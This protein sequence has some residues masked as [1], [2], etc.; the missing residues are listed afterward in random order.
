M[1]AVA[2]QC[3]RRGLIN[4][5]TWLSEMSL[6]AL[7]SLLTAPLQACS[8]GGHGGNSLCSPLHSVIHLDSGVFGNHAIAGDARAA[9]SAGW[10][11]LHR[12]ALGY[13]I[14]GEYQRC[15]HLILREV[16][17]NTAVSSS[18][19]VPLPSTTQRTWP[20]SVGEVSDNEGGLSLP[21]PEVVRGFRTTTLPPLLQFLSLYALF[22]DGV[23]AKQL[24]N[25]ASQ[26]GGA[27]SSGMGRSGQQRALHPHARVLRAYL[28]EAMRNPVNMLN[29]PSSGNSD[30]EP[31]HGDGVDDEAALHAAF[32]GALPSAHH[33]SSA[34]RP[35]TTSSAVWLASRAVSAAT[36]TGIAAVM[37]TG[38]SASRSAATKQAGCTHD[39]VF[40]RTA[41]SPVFS[42]VSPAGSPA[43]KATAVQGGESDAAPTS[44]LLHIDPY[45]SWLMG[46][47]LRELRMRQESATFL[48]AAVS[49]NPLLRC[50]WEDLACLVSREA[51]LAELD[52]ALDGL[53]PF[54]MVDVFAAEVRGLL[55]ITPVSSARLRIA[56]AAASAPSD[57]FAQSP[58]CSAPPEG[59]AATTTAKAGTRT[60]SP[61]PPPRTNTGA[62]PPIPA[63]AP[64]NAWECF[65][66]LFP[67]TPF[68]LSQL[69]HFYYH[70]RNRLD[71]AEALYQRIRALDPHYLAILY[72]YS[73]VLYTKRDRLGLSSLAQSVYQADAFRAETNF[74]VG[75]YY[76]LLGQHDRAA[77]HFHRA[78]AIDPQCAEAWLLLGHAYVE[79]K[80]TTA[81]VEAYRTA[82]ELNER[83]Y[84]GWYNL[85]QIYELLEA[86]HHALY[87]YWHTT[88]LR[89]ADPGMWVA[90]ANC[91][92][93][94]G[95]IAESIAC[96][97]RAE[98]YDSSSSPSYPAYVRRIATHHI[99]NSS[100]T[101]ACV[102]LEKL[103]Q[104]P[105]ASTED[106]LLALPF[107]VQH[108]VQRAR[109][110]VEGFVR[111]SSHDTVL[112]SPGANNVSLMSSPASG[113]VAAGRTAL[114]H[115]RAAAALQHL[116]KAEEHLSTMAEL[117][118]P[119]GRN[120]AGNEEAAQ[121][122]AASAV[123][124][125][126]EQ[127]GA[128]NSAPQRAAEDASN[129][130][131]TRQPRSGPAANASVSASTSAA[132]AAVAATTAQSAGDMPPVAFVR[133][134][135][136]EICMLRAQAMHLLQIGAGAG[137][138]TLPAAASASASAAT[139][140]S[141]LS[142]Q[143]QQHRNPL[144]SQL[145][146]RNQ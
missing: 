122:P 93:H 17:R 141:S 106:L 94:D 54:F 58:P 104:S 125:E 39:S 128:E 146:G 129:R 63:A 114:H 130:R 71:R 127:A 49:V 66:L 38:A 7:P 55:G 57:G 70:Q 81:A 21:L 8:Y 139:Q 13:F 2:V 99:A 18:C 23:K 95:R 16:M 3:E 133:S 98:T 44:D 20:M 14:K 67:D 143:Q 12:V 82:V 100:Y 25:N 6:H 28:L 34:K 52:A 41:A 19:G 97:E 117:V 69:A 96:L 75:N 119:S 142:S 131:R 85:G 105:A 101:R 47:V 51:Q 137:S 42:N 10:Q 88:S 48:L 103:A 46:V 27:E 64:S 9:P 145:L 65:S 72:D 36:T 108:Y 15:H 31:Q 50:A 118:M 77:L 53:E 26:G 59:R 22:M 83:D 4:A 115:A 37:T 86:Y 74:A 134:R 89:P 124:G 144:V 56:A 80:N 92:E 33:T 62:T 78:T 11:R 68:F 5:A 138:S 113:A 90:V 116:N 84:R 24:S 87:Y 43:A 29:L 79:V 76:V 107:I 112:F 45:L 35:W 1:D 136:Q 32:G 102:Y 135:H 109:S 73:N 140:P 121:T 120:G 40:P 110:S 123:A 126:S 91:L 30:P 132:L 60:S 111:S 61:P